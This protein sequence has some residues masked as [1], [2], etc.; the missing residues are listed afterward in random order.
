MLA[1]R[2]CPLF[3][4]RYGK[5]E[6]P[7]QMQLLRSVNDDSDYFANANSQ[8]II[9]DPR[10][11]GAQPQLMEA[12]SDHGPTFFYAQPPGSRVQTLD[13]APAKA[14]RFALYGFVGLGISGSLMVFASIALRTI[15]V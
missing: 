15:R 7:N 10:V 3:Q 1:N 8:M 14:S 6:E 5:A 12:I 2:T 13:A 9:Q 11:K 4:E